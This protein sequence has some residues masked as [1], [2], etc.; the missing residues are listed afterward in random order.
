M[1]EHR[2][3]NGGKVAQSLAPSITSRRGGSIVFENIGTGH[4]T[5]T[6]TSEKLPNGSSSPHRKLEL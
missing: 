5:Q 4:V 1:D 2:E 3:N 6:K